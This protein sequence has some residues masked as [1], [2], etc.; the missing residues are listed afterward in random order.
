MVA[1][2]AGKFEKFSL[3]VEMKYILKVNEFFGYYQK[4]YYRLE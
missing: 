1:R 3:S 2:E 4:I